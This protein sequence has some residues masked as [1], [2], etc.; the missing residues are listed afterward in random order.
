[1]S[2]GDFFTPAWMD[3]WRL[4]QE[5]KGQSVVFTGV[6]IGRDEG[7][8][9]TLVQVGE[10]GWEILKCWE[11]RSDLLPFDALLDDPVGH[12]EVDTAGNEPVSL[13]AKLR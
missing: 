12:V 6:D 4:A 2:K 1:M 7:T 8:V 9:E 10:S 3:A 11:A 13:H 5:M